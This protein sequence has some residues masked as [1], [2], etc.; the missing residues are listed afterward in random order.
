MLKH[1]A[2]VVPLAVLVGCSQPETASA[3]A[4]PP[5]DIADTT[6]AVSTG[7]DCTASF[8]QTPQGLAVTYRGVDNSGAQADYGFVHKVDRLENGVASLTETMLVGSRLTP[9]P[10]MPFSRRDAIVTLSSGGKGSERV[11]VFG[12][13]SRTAMQSLRPG[14]TL[15]TS[16]VERSDF[17]PAGPG[18]ARGRLRITFIGCSTMPVGGQ[19]ET[20]KIF[21]VD[22]V[23]RAVSPPA[24]PGAHKDQ[25]VAIRNRYWVSERLGWPLKDQTA[26]GAIQAVSVEAPK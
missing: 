5:S 23:A 16:A 7:A 14:Q 20:V 4:T 18:E 2:R 15:E 12:D 17:E 11:T 8:A 3:P 9:G 19:A 13:L 26:D 10:T 21:D 6:A 24:A 25:T 22:S 1:I